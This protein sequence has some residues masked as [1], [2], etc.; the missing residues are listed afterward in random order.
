MSKD[1]ISCSFNKTQLIIRL[2]DRIGEITVLNLTA[3]ILAI[4]KSIQI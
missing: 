1:N 4:I 3:T 2:G